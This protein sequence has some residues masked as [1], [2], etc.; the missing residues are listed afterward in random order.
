[1]AVLLK[2][3]QTFP[4]GTTHVVPMLFPTG[5]AIL[6]DE[7]ERAEH[8]DSY[9]TKRM[10]QIAAE[11]DKFGVLASNALQ[12]WHALGERLAFVDDPA[13]VSLHDR[14]SGS[15]WLAVRQH[16]PLTLL[17]RGDKP[18]TPKVLTAK[19]QDLESQRRLGKKHDHFERCYKLGK[20]ALQDISWLT[21]SDF[22]A[23]LESPGL[24][25]DPR[26]LRLV[27]KRAM[28]KRRQLKR[29]EIRALFKRLREDIPTKH[30]PRDTSSM[31]QRQLEELVANAFAKA[32]L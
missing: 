3:E 11:L 9:L 18:L 10:P 6:R 25:R 15:I 17:P 32:G 23:F 22:D 21:W 5:R 2:V 12:K 16:A 19:L 31:P 1:M 4:D 20:L 7:R 26:I 8:L 13:L 29:Q 28:E 14:D 24:E 27:G 30:Q